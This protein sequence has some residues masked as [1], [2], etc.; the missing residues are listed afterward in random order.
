MAVGV[1]MIFKNPKGPDLHRKIETHNPT[2]TGGKPIPVVVVAK[3]RS[4]FVGFGDSVVC[5]AGVAGVVGVVGVAAV[6]HPTTSSMEAAKSS[7][8]P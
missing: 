2:T 5:G 1:Y 4:G 3:I 8:I 6:P 7:E